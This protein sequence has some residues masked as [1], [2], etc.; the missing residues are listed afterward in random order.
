ME[1]RVRL[2]QEI[3]GDIK[4]FRWPVFLAIFA[5]INALFVVVVTN[6]TRLLSI[7]HN[8]L[9]AEHD[10]LEVEWRHLLLEQSSLSEHSRV[11][12]LAQE[13]L[14]MKRPLANDEMLVEFE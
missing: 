5:L 13:K 14:N 8:Q 12:Q 3:F 9:L 4:T 11:R 1:V 7:E 2:L 10:R 6:E